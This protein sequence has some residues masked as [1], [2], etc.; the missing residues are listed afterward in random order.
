MFFVG[1]AEKLAEE[2]NKIEFGVP[3]RKFFALRGF[4]RFQLDSKNAPMPCPVQG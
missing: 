3:G 1:E 2:S 4:K